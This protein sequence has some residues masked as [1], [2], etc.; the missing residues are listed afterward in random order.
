MIAFKNAFYDPTIES[1]CLVMEYA[2]EG[3]LY[4]KIQ[5]LDKKKEYFSENEIWKMFIQIVYGLKALHDLKICHRDLK[6]LNIFISNQNIKIG[7]LNVSKHL[8]DKLSTLVG[9]KDYMAPE[10]KYP[11]EY[12]LKCDIWSLGCVLYEICALKAPFNGKTEQ[13]LHKNTKSEKY[14]EIPKIYS[15]DL[16]VVIKCMLKFDPKLRPTCGIC[17]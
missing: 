14:E 1:F 12:D 17:L 13:E 10:I 7:D 15:K 6:S 4:T 2:D 16:S 11:G 8:E 3:D 9:T 5:S